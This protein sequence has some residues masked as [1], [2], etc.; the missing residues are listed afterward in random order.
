MS[1]ADRVWGVSPQLVT[2][3]EV[4]DVAT[5]KRRRFG[6]MMNAS[7]VLV[8]AA[9]SLQAGPAQSAA[10]D[11]PPVAL[12]MQVS[13]TTTPQLIVHREVPEGT[14]VALGAQSRLSL[15]HYVLCSIVT[16]SG[17][18]ATVTAKG[19]DAAQANVESTKPGPC[20]RVHKIRLE[21]PAPI[22]GVITT[23]SIDTASGLLE[24][25]PEGVVVLTG[26]AASKA[27]FA[28]VRDGYDREVAAKV[29]IRDGAF[30][31]D[32]SVL[33]RNSPYTIGIHRADQDA[34]LKIPVIVSRSTSGGMLI[35]RID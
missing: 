27:T 30:T 6:R 26:D 5:S 16:L 23:R 11:A 7:C 29:P 13:G 20:P 9:F 4:M 35:L 3:D 15:L 22:G 32:S 17:G 25:A 31:L 33:G 2:N 34:V 18:S 12:V 14:R 28:D 1:A 8:L 19:I 10:G 24:I 21:G